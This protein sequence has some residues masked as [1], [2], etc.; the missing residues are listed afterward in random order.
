[1]HAN[2][3]GN[4][5]LSALSGANSRAADARSPTAIARP[6]D[7][8]SPTGEDEGQQKPPGYREDS[9]DASGGRNPL[10]AIGNDTLSGKG[11]EEEK[12]PANQVQDPLE[13]MTAI[14]K[15]GLKGLRTLMNNFPDYNALT[16]GLDPATLGVDLRASEY[17]FEKHRF[18]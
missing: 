11:K 3:A 10:G 7:T 9:T 15:W 18:F 17:V 8:R 14:D 4:G 2:R 12:V 5:L 16:C 1:M 6:Q 13:G